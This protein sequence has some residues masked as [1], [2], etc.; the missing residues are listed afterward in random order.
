MNEIAKRDPVAFITQ[1]LTDPESRAH[2]T[3]PE[4]I[5]EIN[6]AIGKRVQEI[7]RLK[8][9]REKIKERSNGKKS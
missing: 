1:V 7:A 3:T 6:W 2:E 8:R 9:A 5:D 4:A